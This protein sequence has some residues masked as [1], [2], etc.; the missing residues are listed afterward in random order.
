[1][2][3]HRHS[4]PAFAKLGQLKTDLLQ[5]FHTKKSTSK[6]KPP[7]QPKQPKQAKIRVMKELEYECISPSNHWSDE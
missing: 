6:P 1:M 5:R 4:A 3:K 2:Q 7:K